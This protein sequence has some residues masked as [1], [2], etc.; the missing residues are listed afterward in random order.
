[1]TYSHSDYLSKFEARKNCL[2]VVEYGVKEIVQRQMP[3]WSGTLCRSLERLI[4]DSGLAWEKLQG[5]LRAKP[6]LEIRVETGEF[7]RDGEHS[8]ADA[9]WAED[10]FTMLEASDDF[11]SA[12][13]M[14][15]SSAGLLLTDLRLPAEVIVFVLPKNLLNFSY[16]RLVTGTLGYASLTGYGNNPIEHSAELISETLDELLFAD[17]EGV[18]GKFMEGSEN[19][20]ARQNQQDPIYCRR[21]ASIEERKEFGV[22]RNLVVGLLLAYQVKRNWKYEGLQLARAKKVRGLKPSHRLA[23]L[24]RPVKA[25][26]RDAVKRYLNG[27]SKRSPS[28]QY[29]V[30][31]HYRNQPHGPSR[32]LRRLQW[33]EPFWKGP[34]DGLIHARSIE[35]GACTENT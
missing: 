15:T 33:I 19:L 29:V 35:F 32:T 23:V 16:A 27:S 25:D 34:E 8:G 7:S 13:L 9:R 20:Y 12:S 21:Y 26:M 1:M 11:F 28:F 14:C 4:S 3:N 10:G 30:R 5:A 24:G 22:L 6:N 2:V 31:G 17:P 18:F